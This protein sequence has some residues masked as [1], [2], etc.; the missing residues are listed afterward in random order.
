MANNIIGTVITQLSAMDYDVKDIIAYIGVT[1]CQAH[2]EVGRE[3]YQK[4]LQ[5][6]TSLLANFKELPN[7]K[8]L[9][10]LSSIAKAQLV[11][12]GI[13]LQNIYN[14]ELCTYCNTELFYSYRRDGITGRIASLIWMS[15]KVNASKSPLVV[16]R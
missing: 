1:I 8:F 7:N 16:E 6:D 4:F 14:S 11:R 10:D 12:F 13:R 15:V 5:L 3:V 2:F 9:C